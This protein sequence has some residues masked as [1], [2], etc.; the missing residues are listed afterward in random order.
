MKRTH[1]GSLEPTL[2]HD[3]G[4]EDT[5]DASR[6]GAPLRDSAP[7]E[8]PE[9]YEVGEILG[10]GGMG[11]VVLA[12]DKTIGRRVAIKRMR[13]ATP[14]PDAVA[15]F[16]REAHIQARLDHP[17]IVPVHELGHDKDGRPYFT[18]KRLA[19]VTLHTVLKEGKATPQKLLRA[20]VDVCLAIEFAHQRGIV[21]RDLKPS[22]IMLGHYGEVYVLDWGVARV[23][24]DAEL[25]G[26]AI[27]SLEGETQQG[28]VLGTPGYMSP[29]QM[30]GDEI[31]PATDIY[32][33][34]AILF[35]ILVGE[36]LHPRGAAM[37]STMSDTIFTPASRKPDR[38]FAPELDAACAAALVVA[39]G[40]RWSARELADAVQRY[41]DGDRDV[42]RRHALA[43][44]H[45]AEAQEAFTAGDRVDA[46]RFAG[47][48]LALHPESREAA[49]LVTQLMLQPPDPPPPV[50]AKRF[51]AADLDDIARQGRYAATALAG[52]LAF[53]P[54]LAWI[55]VKDW[56]IL[57]LAAALVVVMMAGALVIMRQRLPRIA[58]AVFGNA[59]LLLFL[60]RMFS[61]L[62]LGPALA[63]ATVAAL[64]SFPHLRAVTVFAVMSAGAVLPL[65]LEMTGFLP[66]TVTFAEGAITIRSSVVTLGPTSTP[67]LLC[68]CHVATI[69][70][71][72][73]VVRSLARAR[74]E[75]QR[76]VEGQ[77]WML[78]QLLPAARATA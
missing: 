42:E 59:V 36:P 74:R 32:A 57:G 64:S 68:A 6:P 16:L 71:V 26:V 20:F 66:P 52:Y 15:R 19:G 56:R 47:R 75:A 62:I 40:E 60:A 9:K 41:L 11:E 49:A 7:A 17:A 44:F 23:I 22:N 50:L 45:L 2:E 5:H 78:E 67:L 1:D 55:G 72:G 12:E 27:D 43:A 76:K 14:T 39:P 37:A 21:H 24:G 25:A 18:M 54:I 28:A 53:V 65:V 77:S 10:R 4:N 31:T 46:M 33:L 35:E 63:V 58:W 69:V 34:G 73:L 30:R 70:V 38:N 3:L 13:A 61:P 8:P 29:E 51:E 48:G